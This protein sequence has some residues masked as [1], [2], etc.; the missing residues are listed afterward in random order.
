ME[1]NLL[2]IRRRNPLGRG[3]RRGA[4]FYGRIP[5]WI[6]PFLEP[7][8]P[9]FLFSYSIFFFKGH[10]NVAYPH[11]ILITYSVI[12]EGGVH[13]NLDGKVDPLDYKERT[14]T[15]HKKIEK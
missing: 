15:K 8:F 2:T 6:L 10:A 5:G 3:V 11:G 7:S 4:N 9:L 14:D 13:V 1:P 12:M